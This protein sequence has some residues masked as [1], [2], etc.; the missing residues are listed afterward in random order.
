VDPPVDARAVAMPSVDASVAVHDAPPPMID[1]APVDI[2]AGAADDWVDVAVAIPD[3]VID[4]RYA[5]AANFTGKQLYPIARCLLRRSVAVRL[6]R[7]AAVLRDRGRR[8]LL[9]D[10]YRPASLQRVL[11]ERVR[12][13]RY[14]AEPKFDRAG[15]PI[16]GSRHSRGA[17]VDISLADRDG[18]PIA[19]PTE[20][21]HFGVEA[22]RKRAVKGAAAAELAILDDAMLGAGFVGMP[23][24]WWHYDAKDANRFPLADIALDAV[25]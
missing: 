16:S 23:T 1:A 3:A 20:H 17:A 24:E 9:W 12:D 5:T 11:W 13:P 10:C 8:V 2:S 19:M 15:K 14:V 7:A 6:V 18:K 4:M 25:P 21:D 22:H